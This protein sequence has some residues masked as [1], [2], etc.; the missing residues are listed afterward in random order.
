MSKRLFLLHAA[1]GLGLLGVSPSSHA[2]GTVHGNVC[3]HA[4]ALGS[5]TVGVSLQPFGATNNSTTASRSVICPVT[6]SNITIAST[7]Q[8]DRVTLTGFDRSTTADV[9]CTVSVWNQ[10]GAILVNELPFSSVGGGPGSGAI[11]WQRTFPVLP[12]GPHNTTVQCSLP[13]AVL[14][15][16]GVLWQSHILSL[17]VQ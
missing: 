17:R 8:I 10:A 3:Q 1:I 15:G 6:D 14:D 5:N 9:A 16:A 7:T 4:A 12:A 2:D 13:P 11:T